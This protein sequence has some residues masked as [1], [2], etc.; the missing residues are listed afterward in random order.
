MDDLG[1]FS[2]DGLVSGIHRMTL[3]RDSTGGFHALLGLSGSGITETL[4]ALQKLADTRAG[5]ANDAG[6]TP[7]M[8]S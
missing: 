7:K 3:V 6:L 2:L 1:Q 8:R 5:D 4:F